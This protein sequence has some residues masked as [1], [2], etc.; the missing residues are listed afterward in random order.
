MEKLALKRRKSKRHA[1][2]GDARTAI[3][4]KKFYDATGTL[5]THL[6]LD[7]GSPT[8]GADLLFMFKRNV[9][10]ARRENKRL[11]GRADFEPKKG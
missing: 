1:S 2:H 4:Q 11:L 9:A 3:T 7:A 5:K 6:T 10:K 8:F